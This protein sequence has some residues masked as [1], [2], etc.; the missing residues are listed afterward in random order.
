[1][2]CAFPL[3]LAIERS[4]L[5]ELCSSLWALSTDRLN[6]VVCYREFDE[7]EEEGQQAARTAAFAV[8]VTCREFGIVKADRGNWSER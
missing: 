5:G 8:R 4:Y 7:G 2:H 3:G 6:L 1:M